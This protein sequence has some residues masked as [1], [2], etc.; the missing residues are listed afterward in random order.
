VDIQTLLKLPL[1]N[2]QNLYFRMG[3]LQDHMPDHP[4]TLV[5]GIIEREITEEDLVEEDQDLHLLA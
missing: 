2:L 5:E 3:L 4:V 1:P